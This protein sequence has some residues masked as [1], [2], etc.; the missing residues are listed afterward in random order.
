VLRYLKHIL[1]QDEV[2]HV[3]TSFRE[4]GLPF[5][6]ELIS[7]LN[8]GYSVQGLERLRPERRYIF[9]SNHPLGGLDAVVIMHVLG[10]V[11]ADVKFL[12]N[13]LLMFLEPLRSLFLPVN[14]FGA[15]TAGN[16]GLLHEAFSSGCQ[17]C[18]FP[19]G[20]C[21]RKIGGEVVDLPWKKSFV[22]MA[23]QYQ[24]DVVPVYFDGRNT[25]FFY[26]LARWRTR[27][28]VKA[29]VEMFYL[30]DELFRQ[31]G[32]SFRLT[33]GEPIPHE[34]FTADRRPKE[35]AAAVRQKV[36]DLKLS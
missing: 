31:R 28:G 35:W 16:A 4:P 9:A 27:L 1:H 36:Y 30:V 3:L 13:D 25:D 7:Y 29:N 21:S 19:A 6:R 5:L 11:F 20:I 17:V 26:R 14:K 24:R 15:Q 10:G 12:A 32:G 2:N 22:R 33:L 8:L 34:T 23:Q 18:Y